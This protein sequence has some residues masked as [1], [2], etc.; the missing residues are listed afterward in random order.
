M[1]LQKNSTLVKDGLS[2]KLAYNASQMKKSNSAQRLFERGDIVPTEKNVLWKIEKG[3]VRTVTWDEDGKCIALGYWGKGDL[4]G[5]PISKVNPYQIECIS[6]VQLS[7]IPP[8]LWFEQAEYLVAHIKQ[9]EELLSIVHQKSI[10]SR[11]KQ[12]LV[13]LSEKFGSNVEQG[14]LID[15]AITHQEIAE[16][17]NTT[18]VTITRLLQEFEDAGILTRE[19]RRIIVS[20]KLGIE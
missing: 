17:L 12:F 11:L 6:D 4:V 15:F 2:N 8:Q 20:S 18:R 19:K 16:V 7:V 13:W 10:S 5:Q 14:T 9:V 3:A 1:T